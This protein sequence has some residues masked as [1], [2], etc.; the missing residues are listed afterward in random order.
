M[1]KTKWFSGTMFLLNLYEVTDPP[2]DLW[3]T[4]VDRLRRSLWNSDLMMRMNLQEYFTW[5]LARRA[6]GPVGNVMLTI[7]YYLVEVMEKTKWFSVT[8]F[9]LNLYEVKTI[10]RHDCLQ[11]RI[12]YGECFK[13]EFGE[14]SQSVEEDRICFWYKSDIN[15][16]FVRIQIQGDSK[17]TEVLWFWVSS[18]SCRER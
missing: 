12:A 8:M 18:A 14:N 15:W 13:I 9:L 10:T 2:V 3:S 1:E 11:E 6:Y 7:N 4:K 5:T 16:T 17:N